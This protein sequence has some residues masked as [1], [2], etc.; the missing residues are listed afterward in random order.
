MLLQAETISPADETRITPILTDLWR[1]AQPIV[2]YRLGDVL[3]LD[4]AP[5]A[6]GS[7]WRRIAAIEGRQDD[8]CWFPRADDSLRIIFPDAIRRMI[9]LA[10]AR[11]AEY[12]AEQPAPGDLRL[13]VTLRD[14]AEFADVATHLR[15]ELYPL[16]FNKRVE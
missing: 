6:C 8:L 11:I 5:C 13:H 3:Q 10:D 9:L 1:R 14:G 7:S 2:R 4:A 12:H 16:F 15:N